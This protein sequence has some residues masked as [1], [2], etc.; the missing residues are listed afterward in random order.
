MSKSS[1]HN[2]SIVLRRILRQPFPIF[3]IGISG[4][5][6]LLHSSSL[7]LI[8]F[9]AAIMAILSYIIIKLHDEH[10]I[11]TTIKEHVEEIHKFEDTRR[12]FIVEGLDIE[13]R[14]KMKS[15][16]KLHSDML[17]KALSCPIINNIW[18]G[19]DAIY[20]TEQLVDRALNLSQKHSE[21]NK[22]LKQHSELELNNQINT[23]N[24]KLETQPQNRSYIQQSLTIKRKELNDYNSVK[25]ASDAI[26][27]QLDNIEYCFSGVQAKII[28]LSFLEEE[29]QPNIERRLVADL[30]IINKSLEEIEKDVSELR[31]IDKENE[32]HLGSQ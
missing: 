6:L 4:L 24:K 31:S 19:S 30:E 28:R 9:I 25:N 1:R 32:K 16:L 15:I 20:I 2:F 23:L 5:L 7:T 3:V 26:I 12:M 13:S 11:N 8:I 22:Y 29:K 18:H 17:Q 14:I 27:N 21:I 10:F